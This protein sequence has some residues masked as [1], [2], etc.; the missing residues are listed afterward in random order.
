M[1]KQTKKHITPVLAGLLFTWVVFGLILYKNNLIT[2]ESWGLY[3]AGWVYL[4]C[5]AVWPVKHN[6]VFKLPH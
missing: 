4:I 6:V 2:S 3:G 1:R 5:M